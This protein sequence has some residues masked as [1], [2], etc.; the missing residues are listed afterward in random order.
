M[1]YCCNCCRESEVELVDGSVIYPNRPDLYHL[2][3]YRCLEC[4]GYVG[5]HKGS[6]RPLGVIPSA[7]IRNARNHIHALLDPLWR[8]KKWGKCRGWWYHSIAK[9]LGIEEYH[10][11]W[12]R[13]IEEC[14][15]VWRAIKELIRELENKS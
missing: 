5:C 2:K 9:K 4:G 13:S 15:D 14:R 3:F 1:I 10:T 6:I 12:T 7:E 11:G 8:A